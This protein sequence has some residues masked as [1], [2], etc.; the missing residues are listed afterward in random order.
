MP[1]FLPR[2][3][4]LL[5]KIQSFDL[6][7]CQKLWQCNDA[8]AELNFDRFTKMKLKGDLTPA[9]IS[10][11]GLQYQH[12]A[13]S[14]MEDSDLDYLEEHLR[15]LSGFYGIL[16]PF[17]GVTPY[18]LEMQARLAVE[19][20]KDLY[21]FWSDALYKKL[22]EED[23]VILNLASKEYAKCIE[24]YLQL[25][26][27]FITC[28]FVVNVKGKL[29]Q[30][31]TLAKMARGEMVRFLAVNKIMSPEGAKNFSALGFTFNEELSSDKKFV[32]LLQDGK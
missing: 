14:V 8:L 17:D 32:F 5:K 19:N 1:D 18:R 31:G 10:Y 21:G 27:E 30:K 13:P 26:D 6:A 12:M 2:T 4:V 3:G 24:K 7:T 20:A 25:G 23:R 9:V 11:E 16:R 22:T 15:I 28:E 29:V